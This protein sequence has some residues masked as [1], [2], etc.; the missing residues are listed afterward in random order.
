MERVKIET[1]RCKQCFY[2]MFIDC[3]WACGYCLIEKHSRTIKRDCEKGYCMDFI[4]R[5]ERKSEF[6]Q[7]HTRNGK[8]S[9]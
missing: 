1:E 4:P 8:L 5:S 9:V 6:N 2:G 7:T 3:M